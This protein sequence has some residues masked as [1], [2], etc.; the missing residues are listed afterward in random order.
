M[1]ED[2]TQLFRQVMSDVKQRPCDTLT[3][4]RQPIKPIPQQHWQDEAQVVIDMMSDQY[5]PAE[6]ETGEEL[7]YARPGVQYQV[8][9]KLRRGHY[10]IGAE[11]D[12]HGLIVPQARTA[13]A[14]FLHDCLTRNIHCARIVHGKGYGSRHKQPI[15]KSKLNHWLQHHDQVLA[16]CSAR[17]SDGGTG[18][19]YVLLRR[20]HHH[21][22]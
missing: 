7:L 3:P 1:D 8:L 17:M 12:L 16:F 2:D 11:L 20:K 4:F 13:V 21:C 10:S 14:S 5:D 9:R 22:A 19:V 6:V 15:L 18:A